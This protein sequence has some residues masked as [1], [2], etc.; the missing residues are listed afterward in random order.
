MARLL[1]A[2]LEKIL[3][4]KIMTALAA[5]YFSTPSVLF[6]CGL[7]VKS[8]S[9]RLLPYFLAS[10]SSHELHNLQ[11]VARSHLSPL[12]FGSRK[13][14]QVVFDGHSPGVQS[15][16]RQQSR[17]AR[18]RGC[19]AGF[20]V[21]LNRDFLRHFDAHYAGT[22]AF[23]RNA[24]RNNPLPLRSSAR[25]IIAASLLI[26]LGISNAICVCPSLPV[27]PL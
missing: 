24:N 14:L 17:D 13:N 18:S 16:L 21:Y 22:R 3:R 12:P 10:S 26:I 4:Q 11:A 7:F 2:P 8:F 27:S 6:L 19:L 23:A 20:P 25:T 9:L 5:C 1:L 15:Q